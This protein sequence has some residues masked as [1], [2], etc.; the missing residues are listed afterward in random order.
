MRHFF[1]TFFTFLFVTITSAQ[2]PTIEWA[3]IPAGSFLMGSPADE[4][5]RFSDETQHKVT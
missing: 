4:Q 3:D 2:K 5:G 1:I